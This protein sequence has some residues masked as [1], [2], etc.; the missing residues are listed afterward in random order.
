MARLEDLYFEPVLSLVAIFVAIIL[1]L[2][3]LSKKD[4]DALSKIVS[5]DDFFLFNNIV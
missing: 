3:F 2:L 4:L 5:V 1:L